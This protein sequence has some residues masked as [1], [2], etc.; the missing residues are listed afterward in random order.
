MI[1]L[2]QKNDKKEWEIQYKENKKN[3]IYNNLIID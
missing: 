2:K 3:R 1:K